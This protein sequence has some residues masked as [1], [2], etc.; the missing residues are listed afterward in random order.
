VAIFAGY[1]FRDINM[2]EKPSY[3]E[4]EKAIEKQK[5]KFK[6]IT[7]FS[8]SWEYW[9]GPDSKLLYVS[10][11]CKNHTGYSQEEFMQNIDLF[12]DIIHPED[13]EMFVQ[14]LTD[15][16]NNPS[17]ESMMFR[18]IDNLGNVRW[19]S[20]FCRP[21]YDEHHVLQ[22]RRASNIDITEQRQAEKDRDELTANLRSTSTMLNT[23]LDA[24]PDIIGV[25]DMDH[26]IIRYNKSGY[27]FLGLKPSEAHGKRCYELIGNDMPCHICAT[28]EVYE[29]KKPA[30]VEK[31]VEEIDKWLDVRAYPVFDEEGN[32]YRIIEHLRDISKDKDAEIKLRE[33]Q[34]RLITI[35]NSIDAHIY[36]A[37]MKSYEILFMNRKMIDDFKSDLTGN[38]CYEAFR[39]ESEPC[40]HCTNLEL[41][42]EG[43][44]PSGE[45]VWQVKNPITN[46]WYLNCDRA[47]NWI[48]GRIVRI[49]IAMDITAEKEHEEE[50]K[51]MEKQLIQAQKL[52]ALGTLAGG[53]AHNFNNILMGIQGRTALMMMDKSPSDVDY[54][55]LNGI[56]EY[57]RNAVELTKDLLG[58]ARR[59]KY[60]VKPTDLNALINHENEMFGRTKKEIRIHTKYEKDLWAV[61]LDRGQIQQVLL[62]LY[63]NAWQ[64]MP[65][66]GNLYVQTTNVTFDKENTRSFNVN[67]GR[68]VMISVTDTGIGMDAETREKVFDPFF[69]TKDI[70]QGSGL[71]LSSVYG[72]IKNHNGYINVYSEK[73]SGTTF[74]IYL[75]ASENDIVGDG[76]KPEHSDILYGTGTILLVDDEDMIID[77]GQKML[78]KLHYRVLTASSGQEAI[79]LYE[80][81]KEEIDLIILDMIMPEMGGAETF[82]RLKKIN[83]HVNVML[84]SGYS[85][86]GQ[87]MEILNR[88]CNGFLQKPFAMETL[89]SEVHAVMTQ[90]KNGDQK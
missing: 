23:V 78:E 24:I 83:E 89:S 28:T 49:Q 25:Q 52:E 77:V 86:N 56:N 63:V 84:S 75:P 42:D 41:L 9:V 31:Y 10:P 51:Q 87:A 73:G 15:E 11:S 12:L 1:M 67:P 32:L 80:K 53:I 17:V 14:H 68:Y 48:D 79:G 74:N 43:R 65:G 30:K 37:D 35:L 66:G 29:T 64:A 6:I 60:E 39:N 62:N 50:R 81:H 40:G 33:A 13:R 72:I 76:P 18:I 69:S 36:V 27:Q 34:E 54:E 4:L 82:D 7:K 19:I 2:S 20:H 85:I 88:G 90:G 38:K 5:E 71:G 57:I 3:E 59:G 16:G 58:F 70:D 26:R 45:Q 44:Q 8:H 47:I 55:H 22:G 61:E 21:V 46:R